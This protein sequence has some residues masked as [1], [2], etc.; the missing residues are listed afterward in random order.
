MCPV[1][2]NQ[3]HKIEDLPGVPIVRRK[4]M[5][6]LW[7]FRQKALSVPNAHGVALRKHLLSD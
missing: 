3:E 7:A 6:V 1:S 2:Q 5:G 4:V